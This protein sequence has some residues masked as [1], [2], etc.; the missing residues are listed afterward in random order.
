MPQ[1]DCVY[2]DDGASYVGTINTTLSGQTCQPWKDQYPHQHFYDDISAFADSSVYSS[3]S[4]DDIS[5]FC[6]NPS[7]DQIYDAAPWCYTM[8]KEV[9]K[10]YCDIPRCRSMCTFTLLK[11]S[12]V[13]LG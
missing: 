9:R 12:V 13:N 6:R 7:I 3:T 10:E 1:K 4:M 11:R 5:N 8:D 2:S